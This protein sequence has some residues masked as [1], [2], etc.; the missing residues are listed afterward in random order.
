MISIST[1]TAKV[2]SSNNHLPP[3]DKKMNLALDAELRLSESPSVHVLH[4][5]ALAARSVRFKSRQTFS[6]QIKAD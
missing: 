1:S 2:D 6:N 3:T 5:S 4:T